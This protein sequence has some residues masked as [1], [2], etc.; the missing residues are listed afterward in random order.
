M[1]LSWPWE[2]LMD[3]WNFSLL[4]KIWAEEE[5][6]DSWEQV[7]S[8]V[9]VKV[10]LRWLRLLSPGWTVGPLS[11]SVNRAPLTERP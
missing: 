3:L 9:K 8:P 2:Q 4:L 7:S 5:Y 10:C 6:S 1:V 11:V